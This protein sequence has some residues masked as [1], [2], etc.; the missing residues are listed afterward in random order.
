MKTFKMVT[1]VLVLFGGLYG[2]GRL[3]FY[4]TDG[5]SPSAFTAPLVYDTALSIEPLPMDKRVEIQEILNQPFRYFAKGTQSYVLISEDGKYVLKFFK[6][7]HLKP[8]ILAQIGTYLPL[9]SKHANRIIEQRKEK[10]ARLL[11]ACKL[12]YDCMVNDSGIVYLHFNPTNYLQDKLIIYDKIGTI[13]TINPNEVGFYLQLK[14]TPLRKYFIQ[15][16][17]SEDLEGAKKALSELFHYLVDRSHRGILDRDPNFGNNLGFFGD[18][19]GNLDVGAV[20][21]DVLI[22]NPV[23]YK[24]RIV[25]HMSS[26]HRWLMFEYPE[27]VSSYERELAQLT[28]S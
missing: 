12:G 21:L 2:L 16:R 3:Y 7:K 23:E 11:H 6:Q 8:P 26:F 14:G 15:F 17:N 22:K 24:R 10:Q 5:F 1:I 18:R 27:L 19:P 20:E 25:D 9:A 28:N 13:H 4:A